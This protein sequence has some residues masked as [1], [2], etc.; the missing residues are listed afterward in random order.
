VNITVQNFI[1]TDISGYV[2]IDKTTSAQPNGNGQFETGERGV[3][4]VTL[5]LSSPT[6]KDMFGNTFTPMTAITDANGRYVFA[7]VVPGNYVITQVQP[8]HLRDGLETVT[9]TQYASVA[10][11]N[12][13]SVNLP[14]LGAASGKVENNNFAELGI[15]ATTLDNSAGLMQEMLASSSQNGLVAS[16]NLAGNDFWFWA[17]NNWSGLTAVDLQLSP[18]LATL[19]LTATINGQTKTATIGQQP[20]SLGGRFRILG[21]TD[22]GGYLIRIDGKASDFQ[23]ASVQQ[24]QGEGEAAGDADAG[25]VNSVDQV[26]AEQSWA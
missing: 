18:N 24:P 22:E 10:A 7:Q 14:Q 23:W 25:Y 8:E 5:L 6:G 13:I 21:S 4:N 9:D 12:V 2:Y 17:L 16:T 19:T 11:N 3:A 1:P 26:L 20:N 15:D